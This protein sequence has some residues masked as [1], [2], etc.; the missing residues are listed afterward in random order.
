MIDAWLAFLV[1]SL[2][3]GAP[4][5]ACL[6]ILAELV[7]RLR[8]WL[9]KTKPPRRIVYTRK[10]GM[11]RAGLIRRRMQDEAKRRQEK[12]VEPRDILNRY[13]H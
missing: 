6:C 12:D 10:P 8:Q 5:L 13:K 3:V 9:D 11:D 2:L 7:G 1:F 4:A